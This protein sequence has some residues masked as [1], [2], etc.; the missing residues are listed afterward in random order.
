MYWNKNKICLVFTFELRLV[1]VFRVQ[2][3]VLGQIVHRHHHQT[4]WV[5]EWR[6]V[7]VVPWLESSSQEWWILEN[8]LRVR[9][10]SEGGG[11][12]MG[13]GKWGREEMS[14]KQNEEMII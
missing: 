8:R 1:F 5:I 3:W 12:E 4:I 13:N 11:G 10:D 2:R 14:G 6:I 7:G 9:G